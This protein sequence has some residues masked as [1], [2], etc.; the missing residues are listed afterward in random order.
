MNLRLLSPTLAVSH[1]VRTVAVM[2]SDF[3]TGFE[4]KLGSL[5][6]CVMLEDH[7]IAVETV[8]EARSAI[9]RCAMEA[10]GHHAHDQEKRDY[11]RLNMPADGPT[12][13]ASCDSGPGDGQVVEPAPEAAAAPPETT[14]APAAEVEPEP[15]P[16]S[17][18]AVEP[19]PEPEWAAA[20]PDV[21]DH[22]ADQPAGLD[23][24]DYRGNDVG[25]DTDSD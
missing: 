8:D 4:I 21:W 24:D 23:D 25:L 7:P 11:L 19:E 14:A 9:L 12:W 15:E 2:A 18:A 17:V 5:T 6:G 1:P 13:T 10:L 16:E 3:E 20:P 22:P